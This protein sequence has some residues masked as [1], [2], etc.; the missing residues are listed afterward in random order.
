MIVWGGSDRLAALNTGGR[1]DPSTDTWQPTSTAGAPSARADHTAVW[2]TGSQMIVWGGWDGAS[3]FNTGGRYD[4]STDTWISTSTG[5]APSARA[6]HTAVWTGSQMI[7]WGGLDAR[8][9]RQYRGP[10]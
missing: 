5:G 7:V 10:L 8:R 1:Y 4:P 9:L 2:R 3:Y 6:S